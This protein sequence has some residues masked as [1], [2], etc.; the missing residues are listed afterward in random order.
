[1]LPWDLII[2]VIAPISKASLSSDF[3]IITAVPKVCLGH[4]IYHAL[5]MVGRGN[6]VT[7]VSTSSV[8]VV[9]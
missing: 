6:G 7:G 5:R 9:V 1:V 8:G 4:L 2:Y 3:A